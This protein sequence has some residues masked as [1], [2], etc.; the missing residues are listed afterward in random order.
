[1][2]SGFAHF[3]SLEPFTVFLCSFFFLQTGSWCHFQRF[4]QMWG[5]LL[6]RTLHRWG[7]VP[8]L[9][10]LCRSSG[11][12]ISLSVLGGPR[13]SQ[14]I[15]LIHQVPCP[16]LADGLGGHGR[17]PRSI[18]LLSSAKWSYYNSVILS[19][20]ISCKTLHKEKFVCPEVQFIQERE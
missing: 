10:Q 14:V 19:A 16:I 18:L 3:F 8:P 15:G 17:E 1:M 7:S 20:F 2:P 11:H 12:L 4:N 13:G 6:A 9:F 5:W